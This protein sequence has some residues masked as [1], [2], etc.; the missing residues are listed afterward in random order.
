[1]EHALGVSE[2][3]VFDAVGSYIRQRKSKSKKPSL[4]AYHK[5]KGR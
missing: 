3:P 5:S 1:L 2:E 4:L